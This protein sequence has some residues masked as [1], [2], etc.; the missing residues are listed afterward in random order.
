MID[1]TRP[2]FDAHVILGCTEAEAAALLV[3]K[4]V[5][6]GEVEAAAM[7]HY[8]WRGHARDPYSYWVTANQAARILHVSPVVI[9]RMLEED[10]IPHV[11]HVSGVRLMRR[12]EIEELARARHH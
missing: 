7:V 8:D 3:G 9:K 11:F 10:R 12:H 1:T 4:L 2:P 5:T 6:P